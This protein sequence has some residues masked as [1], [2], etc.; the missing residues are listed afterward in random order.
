M[1]FFIIN[2]TK[3]SK[4]AFYR[5]NNLKS[6]LLIYLHPNDKIISNFDFIF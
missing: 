1:I 6:Y 3:I 4:S 2:K 5:L